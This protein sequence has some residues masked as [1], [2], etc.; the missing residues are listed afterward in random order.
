[1]TEKIGTPMHIVIRYSDALYG[2]VDTI[3]AHRTLAETNGSVWLA[4]VGK[5]L[6]QARIKK[7]KGQISSHIDTFLYLVQRRGREYS[8]TRACVEDVRRGPQPL[9]QELIPK[10][11]EETNLLRYASTWFRL[12]KLRH[13]TRK[14]RACLKVV[15]SARSID[16]AVATSMAG[17]FIVCREQH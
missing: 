8:W 17:M 6:G 9:E 3:S 15:S 10:Y 1:M 5:P 11:Y 13:V 7:L 14:E 16:E 2:N 4:K 12:S